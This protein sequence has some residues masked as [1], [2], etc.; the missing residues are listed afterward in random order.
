MRWFEIVAQMSEK[1]KSYVIVTVLEVRGSSPREEGA[2]MIVTEDQSYLSIGGGNLEYQ[3]I[4]LSRELILEAGLVSKIEDFPLGPKVGQ[5]C[6]GKVKLLFESFPAET[7]KIS[8]FGAGHVGKALIG[9]V[10]QL[11]YRIRWIDSREHEF[12]KAIPSNVEKVVSGRPHLDIRS[13]S[14][15]DYFVVMSHSHKIDF[16]IVQ[17]VL[18]MGNYRYLGLI[19]SESKKKRFESRL[20]KRGVPDDQISRL[21]CPMG[22]GQITGKSPIE[23]AVSVASE[24]ISDINDLES[25]P[26]KFDTKA[27][28]KELET[29]KGLIGSTRINVEME[30]YRFE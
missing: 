2:K 12:P 6:G 8:I 25:D 10:S 9:I 5:C 24:L 23:V 11:P 4:A 22:I 14:M 21:S 15:A 28:A 26:V 18:K 13:S 3:A 1:S 16:E 7:I 17:A 27:E 20:I 19:G 30:E 29:T